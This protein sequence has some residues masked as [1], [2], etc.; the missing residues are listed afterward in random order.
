[1]IIVPCIWLHV[2]VTNAATVHTALHNYEYN[3]KILKTKK[4]RGR[5]GR[6]RGRVGGIGGGKGRK[7]R[8]RGREKPGLMLSDMC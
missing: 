6:G 2:Y 3:A 8:G 4:K 1:M 7:E 5:G